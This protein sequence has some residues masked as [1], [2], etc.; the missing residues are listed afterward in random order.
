MLVACRCTGSDDRNQGKK[1]DK[2][3]RIWTEYEEQKLLL[4]MKEI[5]TQGW[6]ADN[7]FKAGYM[8]KLEGAL[9]KL[10]PG[11]AIQANPHINSKATAWKRTYY[12]LSYIEPK[13]SW[14]QSQR[15]L[16]GGL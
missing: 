6:K 2:G 7:G 3:R 5:V 16:Y 12:A 14:L 15:N 10:L 8:K 11:S 1:S 4:A 13:R 9:A